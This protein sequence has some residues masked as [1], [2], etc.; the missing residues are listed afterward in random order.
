M[1]MYDVLTDD[2]TENK[3]QETLDGEIT[4]NGKKKMLTLL[5]L[6]KVLKYLILDQP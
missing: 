4:F 1:A 6:I 2:L 5:R 3:V